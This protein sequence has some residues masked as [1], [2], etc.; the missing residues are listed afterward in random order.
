LTVKSKCLTCGASQRVV[1]VHSRAHFDG[2]GQN[3]NDDDI[4]SSASGCLPGAKMIIYNCKN[5]IKLQTKTDLELVMQ[6]KKKEQAPPVQVCSLH[7]N[8]LV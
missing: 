2:K 4:I 6:Y 5:V 3:G 1:I 7:S 8:K